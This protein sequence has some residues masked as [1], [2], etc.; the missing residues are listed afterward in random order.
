MSVA[1]ST[2]SSSQHER[3]P[4]AHRGRRG[5]AVGQGHGSD[6]SSV[7]RRFEGHD[8]GR[9]ELGLGFL[10]AFARER[11]KERGRATRSEEEREMGTA[12][13]V[14][15]PA[16]RQACRRWHGGLGLLAAKEEEKKEK[17]L[18]R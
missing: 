9:S 10:L 16:R 2:A 15:I 14:L 11:K 3:I 4:L 12:L 6:C 13:V 17:K 1:F 18:C 7:R 8:G 5:G